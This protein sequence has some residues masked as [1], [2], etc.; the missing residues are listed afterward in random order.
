MKIDMS[1]ILRLL[2]PLDVTAYEIILSG[3]YEKTDTN[4]SILPPCPYPVLFTNL[5]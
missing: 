3:K 5:N 4:P 2:I 1:F